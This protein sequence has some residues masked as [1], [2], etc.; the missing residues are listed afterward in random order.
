MTGCFVLC[1]VPRLFSTPHRVHNE[2]QHEGNERPR[3]A[4]WKVQ[5]SHVGNVRGIKQYM[6]VDSCFTRHSK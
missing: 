4:H 5:K 6:K 3:A 2:R 1:H